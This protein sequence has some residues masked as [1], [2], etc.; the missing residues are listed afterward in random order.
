MAQDAS[1]K[2]QHARLRGFNM[3]SSKWRNPKK[4]GVLPPRFA[5]FT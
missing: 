1:I 3:A 4:S 2:K 5:D